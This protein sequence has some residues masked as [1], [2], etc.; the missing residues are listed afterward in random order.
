MQV[1][2]NVTPATFTNTSPYEENDGRL[3][4][5]EARPEECVRYRGGVIGSIKALSF[6]AFFFFNACMQVCRTVARV[7]MPPSSSYVY[8]LQTHPDDRTQF[9]HL[10][11]MCGESKQTPPP[12]STSFC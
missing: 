5:I 7:V 6:F 12:P 11:W 8:A 9:D 3:C 4:Y 2:I 10:D 1:A